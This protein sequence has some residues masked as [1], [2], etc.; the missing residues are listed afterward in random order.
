[1]AYMTSFMRGSRRFKIAS[2]LNPSLSG[3][4]VIAAS[5][6]MLYAGWLAWL[7]GGLTGILS[8][9]VWEKMP[10][11]FKYYEYSNMG[12]IVNLHI[13]PGILGGLISAIVRAAY[14]KN[15]GGYQVAATFISIA[16]GSVFGL[17]VGM[18]TQFLHEDRPT[19][20]FH[21][22]RTA[23][24]VEDTIEG[25][26]VAYAAPI[27]TAVANQY[28]ITYKDDHGNNLMTVPAQ[29]PL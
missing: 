27:A 24:A 15:R 12:C 28:Q 19:N 9:L 17:F 16:L 23:V 10:K 6:D 8:V 11:L 29:E 7:I 5:A 21:N 4:I 3:A 2:V 14:I 13:I 20:D 26:L 25:D 18:F 22:D 1:M